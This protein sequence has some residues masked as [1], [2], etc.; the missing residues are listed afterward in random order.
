MCYKSTSSDNR[1][2]LHTILE[3]DLS[4][5]VDVLHEPWAHLDALIYTKPDRKMQEIQMGISYKFWN[6]T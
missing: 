4:D 2:L 5:H 1:C 3:G 6:Q